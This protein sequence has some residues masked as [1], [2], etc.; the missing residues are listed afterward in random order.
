M[1]WS[2]TA[3]YT[4]LSHAVAKIAYLAA[5]A[6]RDITKFEKTAKIPDDVSETLFKVPDKVCTT[7]GASGNS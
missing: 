2:F 4:I 1:N 7:F 6:Q 5:F 3:K